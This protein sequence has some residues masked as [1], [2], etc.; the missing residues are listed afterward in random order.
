ML[1]YEIF[2]DLETR[3][4][5]EQPPPGYTPGGCGRWGFLGVTFHEIGHAIVD[6]LDFPV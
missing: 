5:G 1:C 2:H 6:I 4:A 3:I